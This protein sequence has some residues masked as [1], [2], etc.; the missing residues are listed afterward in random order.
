M[1]NGMGGMF[2]LRRHNGL[3]LGNIGQHQ[4][5]D[6]RGGVFLLGKNVNSLLGTFFKAQEGYKFEI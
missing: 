5:L 1:L 2:F 3:T 4:I 6:G